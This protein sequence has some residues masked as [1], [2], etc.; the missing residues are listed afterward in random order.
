MQG[1]KEAVL[2]LVSTI[3][4]AAMIAALTT[5]LVLLMTDGQ[6]AEGQIPAA[7]PVRP[8]ASKRSVQPSSAIE[9]APEREIVSAPPSAAGEAEE[10]GQDRS[11]PWMCGLAGISIRIVE[12]PSLEP[13]PSERFSLK[14]VRNGTPIPLDPQLLDGTGAI[15]FADIEPAWYRFEAVDAQGKEGSLT[16]RIDPEGQ[17]ERR[18]YVGDPLPIRV[19]ALSKATGE[20]LPEAAIDIP[21][22]AGK[23]GTDSKGLY[24][25]KRRVP[26][27]PGL[28]VQV[29]CRDFYS[30]CFFP[31]SEKRIRSKRAG[32]ATVALEP[33]E[34]SGGFSGT[35]VD[36]NGTPLPLWTL[37]LHPD[38]GRTGTT[39]AVR[40]RETITSSK[41]GFR[42]T[43]LAA[44]RYLLE[45]T[46]QA[47]AA[48]SRPRFPT[49]FQQEITILENREVES[50]TLVCSLPLIRI[51]GVVRRA[52][53]GKP[54]AGVR[55]VRSG[56]PSGEKSAA[57]ASPVQ[58]QALTDAAGFF[59]LEGSFL[60][61]EAET[62]LLKEG[63]RLA[64][65]GEEERL[66]RE[67]RGAG[68]PGG[69]ISD[70]LK[71]IPITIS[72]PLPGMIT[73]TGTVRDAYGTPLGQVLVEAVPPDG[74]TDRRFRALTGKSGEFALHGLFPGP[75]AVKAHIPS[76]P[77]QRRTLSLS[78]DGA[79]E[80][81]EFKALGSCTL[82]GCVDLNQAPHFPSISIRGD[83]YRIEGMRLPQDGRFVFSFL[84]A[85]EAVLTLES[86]TSRRLEEKSL[87]IRT[88]NVELREGA[89]VSV[90]F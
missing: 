48:A 45:G 42:F 81:I 9:E 89:T 20:P 2:I 56:A 29:T 25:S 34:G 54:V 74:S 78:A 67:G 73:V 80:P 8:V 40:F 31:F 63:L 50:G 59:V 18:L 1:I 44:G 32:I 21:N 55:I 22:L 38:G 71:G 30:T 7:S 15:R 82:E 75:W 11:K 68:V 70:L 52:G 23:G 28:A 12:Y 79:A 24:R 66:F 84:P 43:G 87:R 77:L 39:D 14:V 26:I 3:A 37:R 76:A 19:K 83:G 85:G 16:V 13:A 49:L 36:G 60:P 17:I 64:V 57:A 33:F 88:R 10:A 69:M 86:H 65:P 53:T 51:S 5:S 62:I 6:E 58:E 41:G 47:W 35:A 90:A 61:A 46:M 4:A 72:I 27:D